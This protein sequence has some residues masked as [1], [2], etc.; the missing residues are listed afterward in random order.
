LF[1][2]N[3]FI[4]AT[5]ALTAFAA[6]QLF[7]SSVRRFFDGGNRWGGF[8]NLGDEFLGTGVP[9][10][11]LALGIWSYGLA[12]GNL[13]H[14]RAGA[15]QFQALSATALTVFSMKY[16]VG[17]ERP[18]GSS[19][20]SF[21]SGHTSTAF[22]TAASLE[23]AYGWK[24]GMPAYFLAG[25]TGLARMEAQRHYLSDV[26]FG[27]AIG[28]FFGKI[29]SDPVRL[30]RKESPSPFELTFAPLGSG[31]RDFGVRAA[32]SF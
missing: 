9:G 7:D 1:E 13:Y 5:G 2:K 3:T 8:G 27:A 10:A 32:L 12:T 20:N 6:A 15:G 16:L 17:R 31:I 28:I 11:S 29:F 21:P 22:A 14:Q 18:D 26:V 4:L 24:V 23:Q 19:R 30:S 25:Y